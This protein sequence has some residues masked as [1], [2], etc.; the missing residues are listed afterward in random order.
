MHKINIDWSTKKL[1]F[2]NSNLFTET[3]C[4]WS[5]PKN[6][7]EK[8]IKEIKI[9]NRLFTFIRLVS[10]Q[11]D[12]KDSNANTLT[13]TTLKKLNNFFSTIVIVQAKS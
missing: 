7:L 9:K 12:Q 6:V 8:K 3:A 4:C 5:L 10:Y 13:F 11:L 1:C 2:N